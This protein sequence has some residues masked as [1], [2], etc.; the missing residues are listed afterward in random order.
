MSTDID[1]FD[2]SHHFVDGLPS[3][4]ELLRVLINILDPTDQAHTDSTR[5][6]ALRILNVAF[7]SAGSRL[8]DYPSLS[9]LVLDHGCKYLFQLARS[10]NPQVLQATLRTISTMIETMRTDLKL[11]QELFLAFTIDRLASPVASNKTYTARSGVSPRP[12]TPTPGTPRL[13]PVGADFEEKMPATPRLLVAPAKGDTRELLLE[14]LTLISRHPSF[15]VDLYVNYDCLHFQGQQSAERRKLIQAKSRQS[16]FI[17]N[18]GRNL[19]SR[20]CRRI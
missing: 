11:Q 17:R 4:L 5:L 15:M 7:E 19:K 2:R 6:T 3:I 20:F 10:D 16:R 9:A 1:T 13:G 12:S 14:T 18:Q 8:S